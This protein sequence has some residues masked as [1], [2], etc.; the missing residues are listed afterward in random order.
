MNSDL[1]LSL[2]VIM[3]QVKLTENEL[4]L[5]HMLLTDTGWIIYKI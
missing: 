5:F 3:Y 1:F 2:N 4:G